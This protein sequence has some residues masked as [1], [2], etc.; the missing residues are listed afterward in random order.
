ITIPLSVETTD[1]EHVREVTS[2]IDIQDNDPSLS[3][4]KIGEENYKS[5]LETFKKKYPEKFD[6]D[7]NYKS[8][9]SSKKSP[10]IGMTKSN[11]LESTWGAPFSKRS[12]ESKYGLTET[13]DY[14]SL[15]SITIFNGKVEFI[16]HRD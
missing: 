16:H 15:G 1:P 11:V 13:W 8:S 4:G 2:K 6:K 9:F 14:K 10:K 5:A 7:G 3:G 12:T